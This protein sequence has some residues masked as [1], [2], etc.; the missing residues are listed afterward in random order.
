MHS[1]TST[2]TTDPL[3]ILVQNLQKKDS[4][5]THLIAK[6]KPHVMLAQEINISSEKDTIFLADTT[7]KLGYGTA[8]FG[9]EVKTSNKG[10][11]IL[12]P[13]AELGGFIRKKTT[14]A[15]YKGIQCIS[16]HGYNGTPTRKVA[17]LVAHVTAVLKVLLPQGPAIFAGD[18]N[19]WTPEH[20]SAVQKVMEGAGFK[21]VYS[22]R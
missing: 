7:S 9:R 11:S 13:H 15:S 19:S 22:W 17:N 1:K 10:I 6:Y 8:I 4:L 16:F 21:L 5:A 18:F 3:T 2:T 12:S 14:V 20:L